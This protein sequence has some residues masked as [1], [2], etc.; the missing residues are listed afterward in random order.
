MMRAEGRGGQETS[1]GLGVEGSVP[2]LTKQ[3]K[4]GAESLEERVQL[5]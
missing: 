4:W 1:E 2:R 5:L 3:Q